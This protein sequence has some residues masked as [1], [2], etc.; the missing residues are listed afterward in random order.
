MKKNPLQKCL[1]LRIEK[2]VILLVKE[3]VII[4]V[5]LPTKFFPFVNSEYQFMIWVNLQF[6]KVELAWM[7]EVK[8]VDLKKIINKRQ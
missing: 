3:K 5:A 1:L 6:T 2:R 4:I 8:T 7:A